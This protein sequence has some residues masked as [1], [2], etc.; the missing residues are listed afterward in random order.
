[1]IIFIGMI[2]QKPAYKCVRPASYLSDCLALPLPVAS[3]GVTHITRVPVFASVRDASHRKLIGRGRNVSRDTGMRD[4]YGFPVKML[5]W[6]DPQRGPSQP[7]GTPYL[8][9]SLTT[10]ETRV[11]GGMDPPD[12]CATGG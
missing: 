8:S 1:M 2:L 5:G 12:R 7:P 9:L 4:T 6:A 3:V 11:H 10:T